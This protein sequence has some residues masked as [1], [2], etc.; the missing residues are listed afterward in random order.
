MTQQPILFPTAQDSDSSASGEPQRIL[1]VGHSRHPWLDFAALL[2]RHG[3]ERL[4]D[5]RN[6]PQSRF[7]PHFNARRMAE[8]LDELGIEYQHRG[9]L[10]G[11]HPLPYERL[12]SEIQGMLPLRN[13]TCL[14]CS[15]G[16]YVE[17]H[18]HYFLAPLF[19][20]VGVSVD[21]ILPDGS[22]LHDSGPTPQTLHK[23]RDWLPTR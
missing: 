9:E 15:E 1:M 10:G 20:E 18:R 6:Y 21:Q 3:V 5:V 12:R 19:L 11:K 8:A 2:T 7:C 22:L 16:K 13:V 4:I 23:M 14:M 17:C